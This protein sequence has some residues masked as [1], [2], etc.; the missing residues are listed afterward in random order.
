[1]AHDAIDSN[2]HTDHAGDD[3]AVDAAAQ[4][5]FDS[6]EAVNIEAAVPEA[7]AGPSDFEIMGLSPSLVQATKDMGY[8]KATA[9]QLK[10]IPLALHAGG[11]KKF[12]DLMVSSQTG[13]GKTAAFLLPVL[14]TLE[15]DMFAKE[16]AEKAEYLA[17]AEAA[18][19]RGEEPAKKPKRKD[20]TNNR[21]FKA[22]TPGA[23]ILCPTREL[24]QQVAN[25]AIDL[26]RH[27][28]GVRIASV[29][30]GMPYQ[31]QIA[32]LQ[33][34]NLIV[35]TP[36]RLLDLQRS[37][38]IKLQDV[39]F[40]VVDEA[41]RML[42][43]G[44]SDDLAEVNNLTAQRQQTMMFS[45]TFASRIQQL[46]ARVMREP[47]RI[48]IDTPQEKHN[49][50]K[51]VLFWADNMQHKRKLLDH[52]MRDTTIEQ[53]IV[54][55]STQVECDG[56]ANDLADSGFAAAALHGA[57]SQ[58]M[59]NRR[60][61][62][63]REGRIQF[64]I[65]TDV[66]A[67]G[68]D[69]PS[70]SHVFN[71][72]LP[73]KAEDYTHRIG[74]TGRAG[75][76]GTA[77]TIAE[78]RDRR[79][80]SDIEFFTKQPIKAEV[81]PGL[82]PTTR[83]RPS[84]PSF[85]A[86]PSFGDRGGD[87]GNDRGSD[88]GERSYGP[89]PGGFNDR[90]KGGGFGGGFGD[91]TKNASEGGWGG[92]PQRDDARG[93]QRGFEQRGGDQRGADQRGAEQ[94]QGGFGGDNRGDQR[95]DQRSDQRGFGAPRQEPRGFENRNADRGGDRNF[96]PRAP[97]GAD[98]G[99]DRGQERGQDRDARPPQ[100]RRA[101]DPRQDTRQD[102]RGEQRPFQRPERT[103]TWSAARPADDKRPAKKSF[104]PGKTGASSFAKT[105][106]PKVVK[107]IGR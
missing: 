50:I 49:N 103:N 98:R 71:Y 21:N 37:S 47:Q 69:V 42:D 78:F 85:G 101:Q 64:L 44:F 1:M 105:G 99:Q 61:N 53:A 6:E 33:N 9:V 84:R 106:K 76:S 22:P 35:A 55:V 68:I 5:E 89:R 72:G 48:T 88:R 40:L 86:R 81:I 65:A 82:E 30:G 51:Q 62:M 28:R 43:L 60:L 34:A 23:L 18:K 104:V 59:R 20:P 57:L 2:G 32:K 29:I 31:L 79:K 24:A 95:G 96:A 56:L 14:H 63:L 73:M 102:T 87:R 74:R 13:S 83:E 94:G 38:Q 92:R 27:M 7:P 3:A 36:G 45:A 93:D 46:A 39:K 80:I 25:E 52:W 91:R 97:F 54:F 15:A 19:M 16:A 26:V 77:V 58:G 10:A 12:V 41:D 107:I 17:E 75:R 11:D 8:T 4:E 100:D 70:I 66:A 90:N 67:R